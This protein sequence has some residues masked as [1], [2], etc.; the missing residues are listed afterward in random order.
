[1]GIAAERRSESR[2]LSSNL[3]L[4]ITRVFDAPRSLVFQA[5]MDPEHL[6]HWSAPHGFEISHC[7]GEARVGGSWRCCMRGHGQELW[8]GGVYRRIVENELIEMTHVWEAEGHQTLLTVRFEDEGRKTRMTLRQAGFATAASRDGH[9][10]GWR[11]CFERLEARLEQWKRFRG[12]AEPASL[13]Q[14]FVERISE[15]ELLVQRTFR[16][17]AELVFDAWTRPE[18]L[19]HWWAPKCREV[20]L[21]QCDADLRPG[22]RYRYVLARGEE[23]MAFSG[24][25][26]ELVRPTRLVFTQRFEPVP[27]A[28]SVVTV[29][30]EQRGSFTTLEARER[31]SSKEAL[32]GALASGMEK[33]MREAFDQLE[34]LLASMHS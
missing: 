23:R 31:Y 32:E 19:Q 5:W 22:G 9:G 1:M 4:V 16:A 6:R 25:Y 8:L 7:E 20:T 18:H 24:E 30:F 13:G 12:D 10:G 14:T 28:E 3:E 11:E 34:E 21:V 26:R 2:T 27:D 15:T 17:P 29:S 33:G